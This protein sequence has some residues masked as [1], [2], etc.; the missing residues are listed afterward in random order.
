[1]PDKL[2]RCVSKVKEQ[3]LSKG[4]SEKEAS[5][6]A[7]A[8]CSKSTGYVK[9]AKHSWTKKTTESVNENAQLKIEM[10]LENDERFSK[11]LYVEAKLDPT[12][13]QKIWGLLKKVG[14][15]Q[16]IPINHAHITII[17]SRRS[18]NKTFRLTPINGSAEPSHFE[19]LGGNRG[20][21]Y[22]LALV[23]KSRALEKKHKEYMKE[24]QLKYD[25]KE[26]KPHMTIVYDLNKLM[27]GMKPKSP[28]A[29]KAIENMFNLLIKD[30]PKQI[31]IIKEEFSEL[32]D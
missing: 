21:P 14:F 16:V 5:S 28:K 29:K 6:T 7:Y 30:M 1:M 8:I 2:D 23:V 10:L 17:Y 20:N 27:P 3:Y 12:A 11:G 13:L 4:K 15:K 19:I 24:Y 31:N 25:Y 18:P 22:V 9:E 26:Y 32:K